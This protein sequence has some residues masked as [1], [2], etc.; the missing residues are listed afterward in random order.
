VL[1]AESR[2]LPPG[3][4]QASLLGLKN[5]GPDGVSSCERSPPD[6][7]TTADIKTMAAKLAAHP[8]AAR[9]A[10]AS[11]WHPGYTEAQHR[12]L[13]QEIRRLLG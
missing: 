1:A 10:L 13:K 11:A 5:L 9:L 12:A 3:C 2:A 8:D 7:M 4:S 6:A